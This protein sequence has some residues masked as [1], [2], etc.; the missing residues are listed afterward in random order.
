MS[1]Q[2]TSIVEDTNLIDRRR[3]QIIVAATKLFASQGFFRTTVKDIAGLAGTSPGLIYQYVSD[4]E[5]ILLLVLLEVVDAY[6]REIPKAI[7]ETSDPLERLLLAF[8]EYCRVVDRYRA[9][10]VLAYR[11]TKS[12]SPERREIIKQ[13]EIETNGLFS[14]IVVE[15][16]KSGA[17]RPVN[18]DVVTYQIVMTA[19]AWALKS[20]HFKANL[21]LEQYIESNIDIL[22]NGVMTSSG[23]QRRKS[24]AI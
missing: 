16:I 15:C 21:T 3:K 6:A 17:I 11:S 10:T 18:V 20:W 14:D 1:Y 4:K 19:H 9:A 2:V 22:L 7:G 5:D 13:R 24:L 23:Q 12:L 8:A